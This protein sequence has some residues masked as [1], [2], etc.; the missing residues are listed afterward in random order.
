MAIPELGTIDKEGGYGDRPTKS[1]VTREDVTRSPPNIYIGTC[2]RR[3]MVPKSMRANEPRNQF[4]IFS[5]PMSQIKL[6]ND[7]ARYSEKSIVKNDFL[8]L[9]LGG[10]TAVESFAQLC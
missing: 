3:I 9:Y 8:T 7:R 4:I 10:T 1:A 2:S 5:T 6:I